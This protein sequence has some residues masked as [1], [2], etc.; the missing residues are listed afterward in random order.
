MELRVKFQ[1]LLK[2]DQTSKGVRQWS[3]KKLY[4]FIFFK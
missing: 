2:K 4:K 1:K 3:I